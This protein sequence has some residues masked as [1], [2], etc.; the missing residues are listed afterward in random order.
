MEFAGLKAIAE[1][2]ETSLQATLL[3]IEP[4][5]EGL[6]C[7]L[8]HLSRIVVETSWALT[9]ESARDTI[10]FS[11]SRKPSSSE[12]YLMEVLKMRYDQLEVLIQQ[13]KPE[14]IIEIGTHHGHRAWR[15]CVSALEHHE[16]VHY[17]GYDLFDWANSDTDAREMNSKGAGSLRKAE[18]AMRLIK[19]SHPG[20]TFTLYR[21]FTSHTLHG[22]NIIADFVFI[23]GG[24]SVETIRGDYEAVKGS[25]VIVFDDYYVGGADTAQFGCNEVIKD[26]P[27]ELLP[28]IDRFGEGLAVQMAVIR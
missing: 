1:R 7:A 3:A 27:H 10:R 22:K 15:M 13:H 12:Q 19:A 24:H 28:K 9:R 21:G 20:F 14:T 5:D 16:K 26:I 18:E 25:K 4:T 6:R 11:Q 17:I 8:G 2:L 23:D